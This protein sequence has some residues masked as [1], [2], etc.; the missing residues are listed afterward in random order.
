MPSADANSSASQ[1][2]LS[3][4]TMAWSRKRIC[5][6]ARLAS[7]RGSHEICQGLRSRI[8]CTMALLHHG[9]VPH[10]LLDAS[11]DDVGGRALGILSETTRLRPRIDVTPIASAVES[12]PA[13]SGISLIV[14]QVLLLDEY[15]LST[16]CSDTQ[17]SSER[18]T[19]SARGL[20]FNQRKTMRSKAN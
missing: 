16:R 1:P 15:R 20:S 6:G 13:R 9:L 8:T 10:R 14:P 18:W 7:P 19:K 12:E 11:A 5:C 17:R 2:R 3:A 4:H